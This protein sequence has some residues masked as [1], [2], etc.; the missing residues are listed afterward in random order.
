V[1][2]QPKADALPFVAFAQKV[3]S[4]ALTDGQRV[5]CA[6][7]FDGVEPADLEGED[8][9]LARRI[10]GDVETIPPEARAVLVAVCGARGGKS[11]VLCG[12]YALWRALTADLSSLAPGE[13]A[14]AL[15]VAPDLRLARQVLRYALGA[16]RSAPAIAKLIESKTNDSFTLRRSDGHAVSIEALPATRGGSALRGRSLVCAAMDESAFFRDESAAVNDA[17]IFRAIAP[18][19]LPGG[20]VVIASTPWAEAG[21]LW[22]EFTYNHGSP[23][24]ALS[25]HAPTLVLNPSQRNQEAVAREQERDPDNAEREFGAAFM[26]AGAGLFFDGTTIDAA[27]DDSLS[28]RPALSSRA[29]GAIGGDLGLVRDA[30]AFVAV[31]HDPDGT[32]IVAEVLELK[33]SKGKPLKLSEV[34]ASAS[35]LA[36]RHGRKHIRT[37]H[38]LIEAAREHMKSVGLLAAPGGQTGKVDCY[39]RAKDLLAQGRVRIPGQYRRIAQQLREIVSKPTPGGGLTLQAPR[40]GGAHGDIVSALV[41]ALWE[42]EREHRSSGGASIVPGRDSLRGRRRKYV[43]GGVARALMNDD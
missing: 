40:R 28:P 11:R 10:F 8:R 1:K 43:P 7:A 19:V 27:V 42:A 39:A 33:P 34:C 22:K 23:R 20:L 29:D 4:L 26:G 6:V 15:I 13:L 37:D 25:A 41:L 32:L 31:H 2:R 36:K 21:L 9:E 18:R 17:E 30:S 16:A 12:T 35:E 5:L 24:T 38:H 14:T 3:L